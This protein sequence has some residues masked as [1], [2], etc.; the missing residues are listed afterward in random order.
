M[1]LCISHALAISVVLQNRAARHL[2]G[3]FAVW[4]P[5]VDQ[6]AKCHLRQRAQVPFTSQ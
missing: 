6:L 2:T 4:R 5:A 3:I 1:G